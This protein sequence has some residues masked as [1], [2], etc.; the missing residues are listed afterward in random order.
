MLAGCSAQNTM[1]YNRPTKGSLQVWAEAVNDTSY[2]W[3]NFP[4]YYEMSVNYSKPNSEVCFP[5]ASVP[6]IETA[7]VDTAGG[8]LHIGF[9]SWATPSPIWAQ[10]AFR[11]LDIAD[12]QNIISG[13]L[14]GSQ[15]DPLTIEPL[16]QTRGSSQTSFLDD[17]IT[18]GKTSLQI[19]TQTLAKQILFDSNKTAY[20][21]R[22]M[23]GPAP[24]YVLSASKEI[25]LFAGAFQSPQLLMI[26]GIG[27]RDQLEKF[28]IPIISELDGV[29]QNMWD[30]VVLSP[31]RQ[32]NVE[33]Y[34]GLMNST[35]RDAA[36]A[37]YRENRTGISTNDMSD[38]LGWEKLP[39]DLR[40]SFSVSTQNDLADFPSDRPEVEY[41]VSSAP[42]GTP[43]L[44]TPEE[45]INIGYLTTSS[46]HTTVTWQH[47]SCQCGYGRCTNYQSELAHETY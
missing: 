20:G 7:S 47:H 4:P 17:A 31:G 45:P 16:S 24:E 40:S 11:E 10:M 14:I 36:V 42:F 34:D 3:D 15:Y 46:A 12:I 21:V 9:P 37:K 19:Y 41:A 8:P 23:T 28:N 32:V 22:V 35:I 38:Y 1:S 30:H 26:S 27:P 6:A 33:T 25:V 5:N 39:N 44:S 18:K 13:E 43:S 29:G 2:L